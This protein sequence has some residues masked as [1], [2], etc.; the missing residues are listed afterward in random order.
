MTGPVRDR[1]RK[2]LGL[3][4]FCSMDSAAHLRPV[5]WAARPDHPQHPLLSDVEAEGR[6][7]ADTYHSLKVN[8]REKKKKKKHRTSETYTVERRLHCL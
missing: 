3:C 6:W 1:V 4:S 7:Q 8:P 5:W 2:E